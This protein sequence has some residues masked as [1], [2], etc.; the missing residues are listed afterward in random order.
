MRWKVMRCRNTFHFD[1]FQFFNAQIETVSSQMTTSTDNN[2]KWQPGW[3]PKWQHRRQPTHSE[4]EKTDDKPGDNPDS[5]Q[6][7]IQMT[8]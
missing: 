4:H 7:K 2:P 8:S 6:M 5:S 3:Q 1:E